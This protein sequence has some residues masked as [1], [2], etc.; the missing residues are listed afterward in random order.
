MGSL[1]AGQPGCGE[2]IEGHRLIQGGGRRTGADHHAGHTLVVRAVDELV[3]SHQPRQ[4]LWC[5]VGG[6]SLQGRVSLQL[7]PGFFVRDPIDSDRRLDPVL[8]LIR[9]V[10][11]DH[12]LVSALVDGDLHR[13]ERIR[14]EVAVGHT[15]RRCARRSLRPHGLE[16][17]AS[18]QGDGPS[19]PHTQCGE[20][21]AARYP[22]HE[23]S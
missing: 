17:R 14:G 21:T 10:G 9:G 15:T 19:H 13:V 8:G 12:F 16:R 2:Q 1:L 4:L 7:Q 22:F 3:E 11:G 5:G 18:S 23:S 6:D 20:N